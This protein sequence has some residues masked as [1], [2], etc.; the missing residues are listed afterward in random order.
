LLWGTVKSGGGAGGEPVL[1]GK[2]AKSKTKKELARIGEDHAA[3]YLAARGY[4]IRERNYRT[5]RGEIDI[6]AEHRDTLVFIEVKARSSDEYGTPLESVTS[7]KARRIAGVAATYLGRRE[8]RERLTRYDVVEVY[9][10]AEGRV[11]RIGV[12]EGAFGSG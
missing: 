10:T 7:W 4:R 12:V 2:R 8:K 6:V 3:R 11:T 5:R 9:L 1:W